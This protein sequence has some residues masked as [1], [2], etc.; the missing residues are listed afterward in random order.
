MPTQIDE[1]SLFLAGRPKNMT[2]V[3]SRIMP[4]K[5]VEAGYILA[6][7]GGTAQKLQTDLR[8]MVGV[9]PD[10]E[11]MT[12]TRITGQT[13]QISK[14]MELDKSQILDLKGEIDNE[15]QALAAVAQDYLI[16]FLEYEFKT[17]VKTAT[18]VSGHYTSVA[19][20]WDFASLDKI[21]VYAKEVVDAASSM[22]TLCGQYPN[23]FWGNS[24][25]VGKMKLLQSIVSN[26]KETLI[27]DGYRREAETILGM[28]FLPATMT[29]DTASD[30]TTETWGKMWSENY[31][32]YAFSNLDTLSLT[33]PGNTLGILLMRKY[34]NGETYL[35]EEET[36]MGGTWRQSVSCMPGWLW[37]DTNCLFALRGM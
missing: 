29:Y 11:K 28:E 31:L 14:G 32:Y 21:M 10:F 24:Y 2:A 3:H 17:T 35:V 1:L 25:V 37:A 26:N 13:S 34:E 36:M 5:E 22:E 4:V 18:D 19:A 7:K 12:R 30:P 8:S 33:S 16:R 9:P 27:K 6:R 23:Y 15:K 20:T